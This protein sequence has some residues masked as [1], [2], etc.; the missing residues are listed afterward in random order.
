MHPPN[1][2]T[3]NQY[4][5][6][7]GP[8]AGAY[9]QVYLRMMGDTTWH[10]AGCAWRYLPSEFELKSRYGQGRDWA[11]KYDDLEPFYNQAE[12]MMGVCGPDPKVEDLGSPPP[13]ALPHGSAADFLCGATIPQAHQ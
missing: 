6:T 8:N 3:P 5:Y 7:S 4:L 2:M 10:W 12:V 11:L 13:A 1:Q 9:Q